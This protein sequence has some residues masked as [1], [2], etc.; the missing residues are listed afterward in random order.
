M[1]IRKSE[2]LDEIA[3]MIW[4]VRRV[5]HYCANRAGRDTPLPTWVMSLELMR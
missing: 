5:G 3:A 2:A 1:I 4:V